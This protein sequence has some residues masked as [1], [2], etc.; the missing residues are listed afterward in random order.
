MESIYYLR[1]SFSSFLLIFFCT[2]TI[3]IAQDIPKNYVLTEFKQASLKI[4]FN[5][6][7]QFENFRKGFVYK[8]TGKRSEAKLNYSYL[9]GDILFIGPSLDTL[10]ISDLHLVKNVSI[11]ESIYFYDQ[12]YGFVEIIGERDGVK[13]GRKSQL[14]LVDYDKRA[15][16]ER[17]GSPTSKQNQTTFVGMPTHVSIDNITNLTLRSQVLYFIIDKNNRFHLAGRDGFIKVYA[18]AKKK[19]VAYLNG[20][21]VN[22]NNENDLKKVIE[23]CASLSDLP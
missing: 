11:G 15:S 12:K 23:D 7:F 13:I 5:E 6:R 17:F 14:A 1:K 3:L 10:S 16:F 18:R 21:D 20:H 2:E 9:Y 8:Q 22:Y 4:P 19:V